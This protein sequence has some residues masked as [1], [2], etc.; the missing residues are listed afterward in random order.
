MRHKPSLI[1]IFSFADLAF[2]LVLALSVLPTADVDYTE[3]KLTK[4]AGYEQ[5]QAASGKVKQWRIYVSDN[6]ESKWPVALEEWDGSGKKWMPRKDIDSDVKFED[7][8]HVLKDK[9]IEPEFLAAENSKT[10]VMLRALSIIQKVWPNVEIF[11]T[12]K[13]A[14]LQE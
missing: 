5:Q 8:L 12:V 1:W 10:G 11:T 13:T 2:L 3:L 7:E 4:V 9:N 6:A 14:K